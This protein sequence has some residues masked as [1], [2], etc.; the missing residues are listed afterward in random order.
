VT[1]YALKPRFQE[2]LR[3]LAERLGRAGVAPDQL[4]W[5][6]LLLSLATGALL[7]FFPE[8]RILLALLPAVCFLRLAL[9]ALDGMVA[10]AFNRSTRGG[11]FLNEFGDVVAD[12]A[13]YL[14]LA[15]IPGFPSTLVVLFACGG[16]L[17]EFAGVLAALLAGERRYDGPMGKSDRALLASFAAL[18]A[19]AGLAP[20]PLLA[21]L[22][23]AA[24]VGLAATVWRRSRI[25]FARG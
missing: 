19:A 11:A 13:L 20:P 5:A 9:N 12:L 8:R 4:T 6:A 14:P 22:F 10:R 3:P 16:V 18:L 21:L 15:R 2:L 7:A 24:L 23:A 1:L 25:V 17:A